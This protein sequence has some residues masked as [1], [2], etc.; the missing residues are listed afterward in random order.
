MAARIHIQPPV[1]KPYEGLIGNTATIGRTPDNSISLAAAPC[2]SLQHSPP[3]NLTRG[4]GGWFAEKRDVVN[5]SG[6]I[7]DKFI[8]NAILAYWP[9]PGSLLP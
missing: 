8:G 2:V 3:E 5:Q 7:I 4:L 9:K 6:G 1:G